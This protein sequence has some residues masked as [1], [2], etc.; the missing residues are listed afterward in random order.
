[1]PI[2]LTIPFRKRDLGGGVSIRRVLP[3]AGEVLSAKGRRLRPDHPGELIGP[4]MF[5]DHFGPFEVPAGK[6]LDTPSHP[7]IGIS[8]LTLYI[9]GEVL[10]RDSLGTVAHVRGGDAGW[11]ISGG[12]IVHSERSPPSRIDT[13]RI[14]H[15]IQTWVALPKGLEN[16]PASFHHHPAATLP[17]VTRPGVEIRILSGTAFGQT[18]PSYGAPMFV[19]DIH[20]KAGAELDLDIPHEQRGLYVIDGELLDGDD[21]IAL[22]TMGLLHPGPATVRCEVDTHVLAIGGA[23]L[24][25]DRLL[26]WNYVNSDAGPIRAARD[27]WAA[28]DDP[29]VPGE[30][31]EYLKL[32]DEEPP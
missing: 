31:D 7:H 3:Y 10:H 24:D 26:W 14:E 4:F 9:E 1:M 2:Q 15:G 25:G 30:N 6:R 23:P 27:R 19:C 18:A 22:H 20:L 29:E 28:G 16:G 5:F 21:A 17:T 11:M 12:G 32:P 13:A 8:T